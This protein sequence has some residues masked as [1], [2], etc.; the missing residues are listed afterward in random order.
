MCNAFKGFDAKGISQ[1]FLVAKGVG[2]SKIS[3]DCQQGD[4]NSCHIWHIW[5]TPYL[6]KSP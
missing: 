3:A 1:H 4:K 5:M 2:G 6:E